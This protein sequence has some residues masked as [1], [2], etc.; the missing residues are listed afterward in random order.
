ME[1]YEFRET[2]EDLLRNNEEIGDY[3]YKIFLE[4]SDYYFIIK[5]ELGH[6][7]NPKEPEKRLNNAGIA[8]ELFEKD[9]VRVWGLTINPEKKNI[10]WIDI[11]KNPEELILSHYYKDREKFEF[12]DD[13]EIGER[14]IIS[15]GLVPFE[16]NKFTQVPE[17]FKEDAIKLIS[18]YNLSKENLFKF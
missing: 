9:N 1:V 4:G 17:K 18:A 14:I 6:A 3:T 2:I 16:C 5:K 8:Y 11:Y 12:R 10:I 15:K 7:L 13:E